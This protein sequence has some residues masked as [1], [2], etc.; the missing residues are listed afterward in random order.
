LRTGWRRYLRTFR[1][2][3]NPADIDPGPLVQT[4]LAMYTPPT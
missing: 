3:Y 2:S 4:V 1:P